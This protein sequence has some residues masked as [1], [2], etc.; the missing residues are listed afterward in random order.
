MGIAYANLVKNEQQHQALAR[1]IEL[2]GGPKGFAVDLVAS[3]SPE[4]RSRLIDLLIEA[5]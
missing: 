4:F 3:S 5:D 1:Y 2:A